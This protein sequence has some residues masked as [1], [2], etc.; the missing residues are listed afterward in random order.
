MA[1]KIFIR[2]KVS[3]EGVLQITIF[4]MKLRSVTLSRAGNICG[5]TLK[6][7]AQKDQSMVIFPGFRFI[8]NA[9]KNTFNQKHLLFL[10]TLLF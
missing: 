5:E 3:P 9:S 2:R 6:R 1:A 4:L 8:D 7:V 10:F